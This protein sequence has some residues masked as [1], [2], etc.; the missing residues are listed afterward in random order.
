MSLDP[1]IVKKGSRALFHSFHFIHILFAATGTIVT[2]RRFSKNYL[3]ALIVGA[4]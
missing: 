1:V 4:L 2:F 3:R